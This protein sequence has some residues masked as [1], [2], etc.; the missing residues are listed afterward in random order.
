MAAGEPL[1]S[2]PYL[3]AEVS[4][5]PE[6]WQPLTPQAQRQKEGAKGSTWQCVLDGHLVRAATT[7]VGSSVLTERLREEGGHR[8]RGG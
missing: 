8:R 5:H 6:G 2:H 4:A 3:V 1:P 7:P